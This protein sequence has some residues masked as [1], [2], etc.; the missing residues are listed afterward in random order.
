MIF[1]GWLFSSR[2]INKV[3][4]S[5]SHFGDHNYL[6]HVNSDFSKGKILYHKIFLISHLYP[7]PEIFSSCY[8]L[9]S[10]R[11]LHALPL[12]LWLLLLWIHLEYWMLL[13]YKKLYLLIRNLSPLWLSYLL[14][15]QVLAGST[16]LR[17]ANPWSLDYFSTPWTSI[18]KLANSP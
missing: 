12:L 15:A 17:C 11:F 7:V 1:K 3:V 18:W 10:T 8:F 13:H 4:S 2:S 6:W 9:F 14:E 16:S 5:G